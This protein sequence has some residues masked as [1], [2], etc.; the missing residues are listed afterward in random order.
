MSSKYSSRV[1]T[2]LRKELFVRRYAKYTL[3]AADVSWVFASPVVAL[4]MRDNME[5]SS[6]RLDMIQPYLVLSVLTG[7]VVLLAAGSHRGLWRYASLPDLV[8]IVGAATVTVLISVMLAFA[9]NRLDGAPRSMPFIQWFVLVVGLC[10]TRIIARA[11]RNRSRRSDRLYA[12]G[13]GA[14]APPRQNVMV[15]GLNHVTELYLGSVAEF[16]G[17]QLSVVGVL[18]EGAELRGRQV[19]FHK[20]LGSPEEAGRIVLQ[21]EN[22]GVVIDRIVLTVPF[23][24]LSE[25]AREALLDVEKMGVRLDFFV[26]KLG[27]PAA[28]EDAQADESASC[29][30]GGAFGLRAGW[31]GRLKRVFDLA[32]S[33]TLACLVAPVA[34]VVAVV[35]ALDVGW[36]VVFW[37][38][39]PGRYGRQFKLYKFRTMTPSHDPHG[40]RVPDEQRFSAVGKLLRRTRLDE[41]PQLYNIVMGEMSFVG[42]RPLLASEQSEIEGSRL[43]V[44][45]GLTGWAQIN[46]GRT[47]SVEEKAALDMWYIRRMSPQLDTR[48]LFGTVGM[49]IN[50]DRRNPE[51]VSEALDEL[52]GRNPAPYDSPADYPG[53]ER[54][55]AASYSRI[56]ALSRGSCP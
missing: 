35:V 3:L 18:A 47:V 4:F 16:A 50:G 8:R 23:Q 10:S 32:A 49:L 27:L 31:Y 44:R 56:A 55:V 46:G 37:Q 52:C 26:E 20:I 51:K 39:R 33:M 41:L 53:R 40:F 13:G 38:Q 34:C 17:Q 30:E 9:L 45:P 54:R 29:A 24:R 22:H 28:P 6:E 2:S 25:T 5:L 1:G 42:P 21:Y 19:M 15:V 36:P 48:I 14:W 11:A 12:G 7:T 43:S